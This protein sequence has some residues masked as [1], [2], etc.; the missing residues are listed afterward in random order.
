VTKKA[1]P[2]ANT[3]VS[4]NPSPTSVAGPS[5]RSILERPRAVA[6]SKKDGPSTPEA[7]RITG[8]TKA[9]RKES[10][11]AAVIR[12]MK[13]RPD[14]D[15]V[16]SLRDTA[17]AGL[18][19]GDLF[20]LAPRVKRDI[21]HQLVQERN[22]KS[23]LKGK[24]KVPV[25][26]S[27]SF[28]EEVVECCQVEESKAVKPTAE[29]VGRALAEDPASIT[30]FYTIGSINSVAVVGMD[31]MVYSIGKILVDSG[32]V[33]NLIPEYLAKH[34]NL[35]LRQTKSL[36]MRTAAAEVSYIRW[37]VDLDIEIAG[38]IS[39]SRVYCIPAPARPSYTLLLGRKWMKQV[40]ALGNY[41]TGTYVI[42]DALG[43]KHIVTAQATPP[44]VRS[45]VP[46]LSISHNLEMS[47]I[48]DDL[49]EDTRLELE[50]GPEGYADALL[51]QV[52]VEA[53]EEMAQYGIAGDE[54]GYAGDSEESDDE[55]YVN[56]AGNA[57]RH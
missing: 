48:N 32:S 8:Q 50:L 29:G 2:L 40:R 18:T 36:M 3:P 52:E 33:L 47:E 30:N 1:T 6:Y 21:A 46:V 49:D 17:V 38:V 43:N 51:R 25:R 24:E 4:T 11:S 57:S 9:M 23:S 10:T 35:P 34:L 54:D 14:F 37:Y 13:D 53:E 39:T 31:V 22:R 15:F 41:D 20:V 55:V 12:M 42:R 7:P 45:D 5:Q 56:E 44:T 28:T 26:Q 16:S 19:W 27:V